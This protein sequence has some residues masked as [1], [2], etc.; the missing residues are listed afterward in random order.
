[1]TGEQFADRGARAACD[2]VL[3]ERHQQVVARREF[4][5][6]GFIQ[7]LHETHIGD[8]GIDDLRE[9][10]RGVHQRAEGEQGD[11]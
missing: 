8:A 3:L 11:A 10:M 4:Q 5:H 7:R 2:D 1:M 9:L 6:Q